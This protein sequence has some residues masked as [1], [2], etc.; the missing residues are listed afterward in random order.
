MIAIS[1]TV[2]AQAPAPPLA[3]GIEIGKKIPAFQLKDQNG[4]LQDFN[5]IRGPKGA[6]LYFMRSADW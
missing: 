5:S 1:I 3:T 4:K 2:M 6:A